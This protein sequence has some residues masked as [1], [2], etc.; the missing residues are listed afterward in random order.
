MLLATGIRKGTALL[1]PREDPGLSIVW[2]GQK[3]LNFIRIFHF[4]DSTVVISS[5]TELDK[6][7][8]P[9]LRVQT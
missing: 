1:S 7:A 8:S 4:P 5:A 6:E 9:D 3:A 2:K